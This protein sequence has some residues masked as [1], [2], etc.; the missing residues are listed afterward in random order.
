CDYESYISISNNDAGAIVK[1]KLTL[2]AGPTTGS[3]QPNVTKILS[4]IADGGSASGGWR[5]TIILLNTD[6]ANQASFTPL[7]HP[8]KDGDQPISPDAPFNVIGPGQTANRTYQGIIPPGGSVT[9]TT[10]GPG[11]AFWQGWAELMASDSVGGTAIFAQAL[12]A[13]SDAEGS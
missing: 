10:R 2:N 1:T 9:L 3:A 6:P 12:D 4:Q 13:S 8:G 7:F 5:T 11:G